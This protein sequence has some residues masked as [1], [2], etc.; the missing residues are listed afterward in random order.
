MFLLVFPVLLPLALDERQQLLLS[1]L[2]GLLHLSQRLFQ[3]RG[4]LAEFQDLRFF[5]S[6]QLSDERAVQG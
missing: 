3:G 1:F 6:F 2:P 5:A 4:S